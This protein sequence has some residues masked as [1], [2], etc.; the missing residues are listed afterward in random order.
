MKLSIASDLHLEFGYTLPLE[1]VDNTDILI[2]AGDIVTAY[3]VHYGGQSLK[4]YVD[5]LT[6]TCKNWKH[7]LVIAGNHEFYNFKW[8][9]TIDV[10]REF[11]A[12]FDNV[13]FLEDDTVTIDGIKFSGSTLW[14]NFNSFETYAMSAAAFGMN[15]FNC[16]KNEHLGGV[17]L[18]PSMAYERHRFSLGYIECVQP[19]VVIS[20]HLPHYGSINER[21]RD[22][23]AL[24]YSFFS[25]LTDTIERC[26][27]KL[28]IH[29]HTHSACDYIVD[30]TRIVCHPKGYP[31]ERSGQYQPKTVEV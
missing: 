5:F 23:N 3:K 18:R 13:T 7:V 29:G 1:N 8:Y 19:D 14:T 12:R 27:P 11:Y 24:N 22:G 6:Y 9:E 4:D 30:Q 25:D 21:Y 2:L 31:N 20:H 17:V 10:L 28:W 16:I 15:D 26:K